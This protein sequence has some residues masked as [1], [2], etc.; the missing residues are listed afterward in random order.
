MGRQSTMEILFIILNHNITF[1]GKVWLVQLVL[2][3]VLVLL[4]A[5]Y[6]LHEDDRER[7]VCN[8][9]QP[10][11]ADA[12]YDFLY[13]LSAVR[14]WLAQ[15]IAACLPYA[16]FV[17][18]V[19]HR[20]SADLCAETYPPGGV[21]APSFG[22]TARGLFRKRSALQAEWSL[23]WSFGRAYILQL[24]L[25]ILFEA[26]FGT[27]HYGLFG[28]RVPR[29]LLCYEPPCTSMAECFTSRP[30]EKTL[31]LNFMLGVSASSLLLSVADLI[32]AVK[33]SAR[34]RSET[35]MVVRRTYDAEEEEEEE[36]DYYLSPAGQRADLHLP[37][38]HDLATTATFRKRGASQSSAEEVASARP[39]EEG[40]SAIGPSVR[41]EAEPQ[42][43]SNGNNAHMQAWVEGS[44]QEDRGAALGPT[45]PK[46]TPQH[47]QSHLRPLPSL[48]QGR[49][50]ITLTPTAPRP[51]GMGQYALVD[52]LDLQS[53]CTDPPE[54]RAWV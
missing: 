48:Q 37:L 6:P 49:C 30:S 31:V 53:D 34:R 20:V 19:V 38:T 1:M 51:R 33:R 46:R 10:G 54:R 14:L 24:L 23:Q 9:I 28:F 43:N 39:L 27:A 36:E 18:Y 16:V 42:S 41:S 52:M 12:C 40:C 29:K 17:V 22:K 35:E 2:L 15:L 8:T 26:G 13:P 4:L 45:D 50:P 3:R 21:N 7:F 32:C 11:C 25:R 44:E 5:V 47:A